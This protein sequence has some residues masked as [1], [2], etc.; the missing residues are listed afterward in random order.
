M[1]F[2]LTGGVALVTGAGRGLGRE[3]ALA[4]AAAGALVLVHGRALEPLEAVAGEAIARGGQAVPLP[5]DLGDEASV[6]AA[7]DW[8][9]QRFGPVTILVNNAGA[10]D[11][12]PL[13]DLDRGAVRAL[14]EIDLVAPFDLARQVAAAMPAGGRIVNITSIAGPIARGGDAAYT[15][16]KGGLDALTRALAAE[17][18]PRGITVNAVAPGYF[19]TEAN[20]AMVEDAGVADWLARRTSLGRW[21]RPAEIAGA[22]VFLASPAAAYVTGQTLAVDGGY[23]GHF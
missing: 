19:A 15:A 2:D 16:A 8:A 1:S 13:A 17:L 12:R 6:A 7:L 14:L 4:L 5:F 3:I 23:L 20:R 21:G 9:G 10:R 11:R 18:G 22:V